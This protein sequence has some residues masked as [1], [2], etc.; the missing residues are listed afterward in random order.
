MIKRIL[1][2][3]LFA[4]VVSA[5]SI[6]GVPNQ[7][8]AGFA[9]GVN[10]API[11]ATV[12]NYLGNTG[13]ITGQVECT[14]TVCGAGEYLA[15]VSLSPTA[16]ASLGTISLTLSFTDTA[17][18]QTVTAINAL[19][20]TTKAP[21]SVSYPFWSTGGANITWSTTVAGITGSYTYDVHVR[22]IRLG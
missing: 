22:L 6:N 8:M 20:L 21:A 16:T 19:T 12:N 9:P 1:S 14:T 3:L 2:V 13:A 7:L 11:I 4:G 5:Q 18:A 15:L 10:G 17:Q